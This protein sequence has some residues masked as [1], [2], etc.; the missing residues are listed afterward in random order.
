MNSNKAT[1]LIV[2]DVPTNLNVLMKFL[3]ST[4][5]KVLVAT[6]GMSALEQ[7]EYTIPDVILLDV[8]MPGMDGFETCQRLKANPATQDIPVLFMT[9]LSDT[10]DKVRGFD[11]GAADYITKPLHQEEVVARVQAHLALHRQRQEIERLR[12]QDR[13]RYE[14][15]SQYKDY[16]LNTASH[17]LKNPLSSII[18]S[19]ALL[20]RYLVIGDE[21]ANE[22][23]DDIEHAAIYMRDLICNLL[24][25]AR[26][27]MGV[28]LV[29]DKVSLSQL[30]TTSMKYMESLATEKRIALQL[31][32]P[33]HDVGVPCDAF[34]INQVLQ[35]LMSNALKYT[36]EGGSVEVSTHTDDRYV[37]VHVADTG[38]GIPEPDMPHLFEKFYRVNTS[39]HR[40]PV[41][42]GLGLS[43][44]QEIVQQHGGEITVQSRLGSGTT[45]TFSLPLYEE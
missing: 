20:R 4:G 45:F 34:Q 6:D 32:Q 15:L 44:V 8:M 23:I 16:L 7:A 10:V 3:Q 24:D 11:L 17:D 36:A 2:D 1:I 29:K 41:G 9:A 26:L 38:F 25:L 33:D 14:T 27:E 43:I 21:R 22:K 12:E 42:T 5:F 28:A 30:L 37:Y 13:V 40:A 35:N 19:V 39:E 18:M 31:Q